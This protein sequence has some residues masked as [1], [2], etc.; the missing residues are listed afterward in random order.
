[1]NA[2]DTLVAHTD[3]HGV[4]TLTMNRPSRRN[5]FDGNLIR[6][7]LQ[8]LKELSQAAEL[9]VLVV[10]GSGKAFSSGADLDWMRPRK[11]GGSPPRS[12][13]EARLLA[14]MMRALHDFP[15]PT[16]ARVNGPAFG[17][18]LGLIAACDIALAAR[19]AV[20]AF[21][22]VRLGLIPAVIAP[23][24]VAAIGVRQTRRLFLTGER[25]SSDDARR[26][27]LVHEVIDERELDTAVAN[28]VEMLLRGGPSAQL[29]CKA[30]LRQLHDV[31]RDAPTAELISR[32][33]M[34]AEGREGMGAFLEKREPGWVKKDA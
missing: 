34:S 8:A 25:F 24:V 30:L 12:D 20:F 27:G 3:A 29:E 10:T 7:L 21:S 11:A 14:E 22:E 31:N 17:G 9:R 4:C 18:A 16:L 6:A 19:H 33:R 23:Y 32:L 26:F 2:S 1:M 13:E 15:R 5:A 28:H